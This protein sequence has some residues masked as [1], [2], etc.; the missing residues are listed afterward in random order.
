[1]PLKNYT[2]EEKKYFIGR[3]IKTMRIKDIADAL[4]CSVGAVYYIANKL[5]LSNKKEWYGFHDEFVKVKCKTMTAKEIA[6]IIGFSKYYVE[7]A[8]ERLGLQAAVKINSLHWK[9]EHDELLKEK[10][11]TMTMV[12]IAN[13]TGF[14][15]STIK[16]SAERQ[17]L[18]K[19][20]LW[21]E[22]CDEYLIC[23]YRK[24]SQEDIA[25]NLGTSL[26]SIYR[27]AKRLKKEK[28]ITT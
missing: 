27:H 23:H 9:D 4:G 14:P 22:K 24:M 7:K 1:M 12:D 3:N 15:I 21:D 10:F 28:R 8:L 19:Y 20:K 11:A 26:S 16:A 25:K 17:G 2:L 13:E 6:D 5:G 18:S